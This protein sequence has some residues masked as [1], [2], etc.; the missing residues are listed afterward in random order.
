MILRQ[1]SRRAPFSAVVVLPKRYNFAQ[2][3]LDLVLRGWVPEPPLC[4]S[5]CIET[6]RALLT[7]L[8]LLDKRTPSASHFSILPVTN[9]LFNS[10][11]NPPLFIYSRYTHFTHSI[12]SIY[13]P[14]CNFV[15][16]PAVNN[17]KNSVDH[18][19]YTRDRRVSFYHLRQHTREVSNSSLFQRML[20]PN[21]YNTERYLPRGLSGPLSAVGL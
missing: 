15:I 1:V 19:H 5:L 3:N 7:L 11:T 2:G 12:P 20:I 13:S 17:G 9:S 4:I 8:G 21:I 10:G 14:P 18:V 6:E 16:E